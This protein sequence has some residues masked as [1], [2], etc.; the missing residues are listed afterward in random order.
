MLVVLMHS[1]RTVFAATWVAY[2]GFYLCRKDFSVLMPLFAQHIGATR[3]LLA[4][5]LF[6]YSAAYALGQLCAGMLADRVGPRRVVTG[7]MLLSAATTF[8]LGF[9]TEP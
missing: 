7:G 4:N 9:T 8:A 2:A 6:V 5:V 1:A 3:E